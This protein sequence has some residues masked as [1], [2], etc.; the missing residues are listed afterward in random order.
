MTWFVVISKAGENPD[1]CERAVISGPDDP[2]LHGL[3]VGNVVQI[4]GQPDY[5]KWKV[6]EIFERRGTMQ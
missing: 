3:H 6:E 1:Q 2:R 4:C 5:V